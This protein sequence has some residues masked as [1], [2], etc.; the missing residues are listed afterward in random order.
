MDI[1]WRASGLRGTSSREKERLGLAAGKQAGRQ[2]VTVMLSSVLINEVLT[3]TL[4]RWPGEGV[5]QCL[6]SFWQRQRSLVHSDPM[7]VVA[8]M[9]VPNA[10]ASSP[11]RSSRPWTGVKSVFM[12]VMHVI[13]A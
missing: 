11:V 13:G 10:L 6:S 5:L 8:A 3:L 2:R 12:R 7:R 4:T 9:A 1:D